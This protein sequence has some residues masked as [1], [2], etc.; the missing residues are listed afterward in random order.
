MGRAVQSAANAGANEVIVADGGSNDGTEQIAR[1]AGAIVVPAQKGRAVQQ[2]A[3]A[4]AATDPDVFLFLHADN[5]LGGE[6]LRQ[7]SERWESQ[8][9]IAGAFKQRIDSQRLVYRFLEIGNGIRAKRLRQPYGDQGIFVS[10]TLF[11]ELNGFEEVPLMEEFDLMRRIRRVTTPM[12]LPGPIYVDPR[13][14]EQNGIVRQT[15][16]N[17]WLATRYF[18]GASPR[19]LARGY[20]D[21]QGTE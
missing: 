18:C 16:R 21:H 5:W 4:A 11:R 8:Q 20:P 1:D 3:G 9:P 17:W 19:R 13:R 6:C 10:S 14:W 12:L 7:I 15:V 2:N